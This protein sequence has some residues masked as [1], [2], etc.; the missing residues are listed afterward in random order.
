M[1]SPDVILRS[2]KGEILKLMFKAGLLRPKKLVSATASP[3]RKKVIVSMTSYGR[4]VAAVAPYAIMSIMRQSYRPDMV[5]LWLD[6]DNWNESNLP[7]S[8]K[9]LVKS[10]LTVKFCDDIKSYKKLVPTL[11]QYP[12]D[13]IFTVDD[14]IYYPRH[15]LEKVMDAY[16]ENNDRII[17]VRGYDITF[18]NKTGGINTYNEWRPIL[19][20]KLGKTIFP[21]GGA[22]CLYQSRL[23]HQ[24]ITRA[25]LFMRLAPMADDIWFF[26]MEYLAG[27]DIEILSISDHGTISIDAFYQHFNKG[28]NLSCFNCNENMNDRQMRNVMEHY[29]ISDEDLR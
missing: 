14:D 7:N 3:G 15:M 13:L 8:I 11:S 16:S 4:R 6:N 25:D 18:D 10:G 22:G 21:T 2:I 24:D 9:R 23:L 5:I 19:S 17:C 29:H 26:F 20:H 27:T 12:D 28:S 1:T